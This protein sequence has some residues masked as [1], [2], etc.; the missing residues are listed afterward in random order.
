MKEEEKKIGEDIAI[1]A[2]P[3]I[4]KKALLDLIAAYIHNAWANW[5][6]DLLT[7]FNPENVERCKKVARTKFKD[8]SE[9]DKE[10]RRIW[11]RQVLKLVGFDL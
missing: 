6:E 5:V 1:L 4:A 9:N 3:R 11:A 8:L 10:V 2:H 7:N